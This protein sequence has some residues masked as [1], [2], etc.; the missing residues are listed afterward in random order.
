MANN[1]DW[2]D[3]LIVGAGPVGLFLAN[4]CA[5]RGLRWRLIEERSSQSEHSKALAIFPRTLEIFDMA[6]IVTPFLEKANRVTDV[7]VVTHGRT[8]AHMKFEPAESPYSFVAMVPQDVTEKLLVEELQRRGG[9]VEYETKF[10]SAEQ[11]GRD[12]DAMVERRGE[13][14]KV[15]ASIVVGCDG[16]H[17]AV[18]HQ[19]KLPFEGAE[20]HGSFLLADVET[21]T[22]LPANELRLCPS[23]FG[24]VAIFPMSAT[25]RRVV[26]TIDNTEGD[27]PSLDLVRSILAQRAPGGIEA[28][29]LN[30]SS[31]F[32]IHH[33]QV[34]RLRE[35]RMF[36]AGDA[37]HI[38]SPFGGQGMNT[39]LHDAWN[40]VWKLDLFLKGRGNEQ[41]LDSYGSERLPVIKN[42]IETT[43]L[44]T[45]VMGTPNKLAQTLRD[46]V[47]PMVSRLA[48]FQH[49]FVQRLSELG[50]AYPQSPIVEGPGKRFFDDSLRGGKGILSRFVLF[51]GNEAEPATK[52]E[53]QRF[54][55]SFSEIVELRRSERRGVT[56]VRPDGYIAFSSHDC[57]AAAV[58][59]IRSVLQRQTASADAGEQLDKR[60]MSYRI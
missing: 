6:G 23:E 56:L 32:R 15:R 10:I 57:D 60:M 54:V 9:S 12:V 45:K 19:L 28:R 16:A 3:V 21:N 49:G 27:A 47:I 8:L 22:A 29:A 30:W 52:E 58:R 17:S 43:D 38:H 53:A 37:A 7:T 25:R 5:R 11:N 35:G 33:R 50:I 20:Y 1:A 41:L 2:T 46:A 55:D 48:P 14:N 36:I 42:V 59:E 4:E 44:M 34:A 26:A 39:G 13:S 40:L 51:F 24:P 31:Y 18:R